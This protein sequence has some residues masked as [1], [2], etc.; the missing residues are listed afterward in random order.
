MELEKGVPVPE[1][2]STVSKFSAVH[3]SKFEIGDSCFFPGCAPSGT[4]TKRNSGMS[5]TEY[6]G[7]IQY[8]RRNG[9]KFTARTVVENGTKGMRVWRVS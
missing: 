1:P 8:A 9:K 6:N 3:W 4:K 5:R 2:I 7:C